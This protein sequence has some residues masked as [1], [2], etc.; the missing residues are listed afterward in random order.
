VIQYFFPMNPFAH[1]ES[2]EPVDAKE[3]EADDKNG[4][5]RHQVTHVHPEGI[6]STLGHGTTEGA[7]KF[8][9]SCRAR[10]RPHR[11]DPAE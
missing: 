10:N 6:G 8:L 3:H 5:E 2:N 11:P 1:Q 4:G 9:D 7:E